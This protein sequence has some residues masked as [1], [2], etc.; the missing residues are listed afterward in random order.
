VRTVAVDI[1]RYAGRTHLRCAASKSHNDFLP[2]AF[3]FAQRAL[4]AAA[5]LARAFALIFLLGFFAGFP[6][7]F[8]H[9]AF[10]AAAILALTAADLLR[11]PR[12]FPT[13]VTNDGTP[14]IS[15]RSVS[16]VAICSLI[17]TARWSWSSERPVSKLIAMTRG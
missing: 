11:L 17:A 12:R 16:N 6:L 15:L 9:R 5:R 1:A 8:A 2:A 3:A 13:E 14:R 4:A 10:C 7:R